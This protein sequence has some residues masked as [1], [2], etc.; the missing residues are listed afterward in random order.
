MSLLVAWVAFPLVLLVVATGCGLL[1]E[2]VVGFDL[3]GALIPAVGVALVIVVCQ[4]LTLDDSLAKLITPVAVALAVAG[5]GLS[6]PWLRG[7]PD[8]W[9]LGAALAVLA[10][11]VAPIVASGDA[12]FAGFIKLDDTATW[13]ALTDR[14]ME[15]GRD[16]NGLAPSTYEATLA[17]NLGAGYPVGV[18]LPLGIGRA[19]VGQDLAWV[20]QPYMAFLAAVLALGLW[21]V[22]AP[23]VRSRPLRAIAA[24][25]GAQSALLFGY[26]L[27]GGIKEV[28]GAALL[29]TVAGLVAFAI[30]EDFE[31]RALVPL[32]VLSAAL[33]GVLSGGGGIWLVPPLLVALAV[34]VRTLGWV[35]A[36]GRAA[37][38]AVTTVV[39][40]IPVLVSGGLKPPT[41]AGLTSATALGNLF[42]PLDRLQLFGVWPTGDFRADP[43][44]LAATYVLIAVVAGAALVGLYAAWRARAWSLLIYVIGILAA[45]LAISLIGSPWVGGKALA[46]AA[47]A[48]PLAAAAG[49]AA[50]YAAGRRVEGVVIL[51]AIAGGVIWSNALAYRDVN[52]APRDQLAEL[53]TIGHRIAGQG[54]T[55]MT[56]YEPYGVRHFLRDA[57][58][59]GLSE[60]RR[61]RIPLRSG[62]LVHKGETADTDRLAL[63]GLLTY[64]TLV[65]RRSP[66]QSRPP[67]PYRLIWTGRYYEVWQRPVGVPTNLLDHLPLGTT[68]D[69]GGVPRCGAVRR[70][71][72]EA[73]SRGMLAAVRRE[74]VRVV[75]MGS[76]DHP[77]AW[78]PASASTLLPITPGTADARVTVPRTAEY[79]IWLGGSVRPQV[80]LLVDGRAVGS[81]RHELNNEGQYVL[82]GQTTLDRGTHTIGVRFHGS[83]LHPGSGG[84]PRPIG[85]LVVNSQEAAETGDSVSYYPSG[86]A[87]ELCGARWD[88]VE[89]LSSA[90]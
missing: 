45:G 25:V 60:L 14:V 12:T 68:T 51:A 17:F 46:T 72:R 6:L 49:G 52:L 82:L 3:P 69:P 7:G 11:F 44:D 64:R 53:E 24:F 34:V 78:G 31:T 88:W 15:H 2:R 21:E 87:A 75:G 70:L 89:A 4:F 50:L 36:I 62:A 22:A 48:I 47:P 58:A 54:P 67:S 38:F 41:S 35:P 65:L 30:R 26:Y 84:G 79:A 33:I 37:G 71:A 8:P 39:L 61:R 90:G 86:R 10:V 29:A 27:W 76:T 77:P 57:D 66:A 23:L 43:S 55:L 80:D 63:G 5:F 9:A 73:G 40:S 19:L 16:L 42:H 74:P 28:A 18:F 20:I 85:P 13:M 81:V 32:A 56:E 1:V 59:E 83:D